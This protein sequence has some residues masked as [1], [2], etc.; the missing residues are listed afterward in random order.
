MAEYRLKTYILN[1]F[2]NITWSIDEAVDYVAYPLLEKGFIEPFLKSIPE[3]EVPPEQIKTELKRI[4]DSYIQPLRGV[5]APLPVTLAVVAGL[6]IMFMPQIGSALL[7]PMLEKFLR[8]PANLVFRPTLL[9][10]SEILEAHRR[11]IIPDEKERNF[12][13][14]KL[15]LSGRLIEIVDKLQWYIPSASDIIR[16]AVREVY[17]EDIVRKWGMDAGFAELVDAAKQDMDSAA[18]SVETMRKYWRAHWVLPSVTQGY[19]M[20]HRGVIDIDDLRELMKMQDIMPGWI[21]KL[22]AISYAPFTRVDV[23][24]M[25]KLGVLS[26]EELVRAYMDLGYDEEKAKKLAEFTIRY[27]AKPEAAEATEDDRLAEEFMKLTR[28]DILKGYR[29]GIY[30]REE[31]LEGLMFVGFSK[32]SAE[33]LL[34]RE[35]FD[36]ALDM[37]TKQVNII[38]NYYLTGTWDRVKTIAELGKLGLPSKYTENLLS[39]WEFEKDLKPKMPSKAELF[40]FYREGLIDEETLKKELSNLGYSDKYIELYVKRLKKRTAKKS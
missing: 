36:I 18:L 27:N 39:L 10:I 32:E 31:A 6:F 21:D 29:L 16:F 28:T 25:H 20:L 9:A 15:G 7:S 2:K 34:E 8:Q 30:S 22:I 14:A 33:Y 4:I 11:G 5:K 40:A 1:A 38:K 37:T 13:L 35:D 24:R 17:R 12:L 23:R 19:E 26:D 3:D